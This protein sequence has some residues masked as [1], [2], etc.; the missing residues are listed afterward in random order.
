M[1]KKEDIRLI[2]MK[3]SPTQTEKFKKNANWQHNNVTKNVLLHNNNGATLDGQL[4][5]PAVT[6]PVV[7]VTSALG[8]HVTVDLWSLFRGLFTF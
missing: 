2:S 1:E 4:R 3:K 8:V 7:C 6:K 5:V